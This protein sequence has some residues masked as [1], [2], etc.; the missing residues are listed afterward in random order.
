MRLIVILLL[1]LLLCLS[2]F[3][4]F[5]LTEK[6]KNFAKALYDIKNV[7]DQNNQEFFLSCGTLL[8]CIREKKFIEYDL[9]IDLGIFFDKFN[10]K[11]KDN[12]LESKKFK[13]L[14]IY[15]KLEESYELTFLHIETNTKID[16]FLHYPLKSYTYYSASFFGICDNKKEK[17]CKWKYP[18][19]GLQYRYFING[20]YL[21]PSNYYQYLTDAYGKWENPKNFNYYEG[22]DTHYKNLI[23]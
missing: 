3:K 10:P 14:N 13:L 11:I 8:G 4:F 15:G 5:C 12:I 18:I 6:Q 19:K 22:L 23:N 21:I 17:Y 2:P 1:I 16:L 7:L 9:D 20:F